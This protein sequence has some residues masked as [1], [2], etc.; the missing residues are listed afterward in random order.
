MPPIELDQAL[1]PGNVH[2][3]TSSFSSNDWTGYFYPIGMKPGDFL[4][5]YGNYFHT[6]EI[7]ATW[8]AMPSKRVVESWA[9]RTPENFI[10]SLKVPK[11]ITH[12]RYLE[13]CASEWGDFLE[14]L[15]PLGKKLGPLLLQ[16]PVVAGPSDGGRDFVRRLD[17][18]LEASPEDLRVVVE[19]RNEDWLAEPLLDLLRR[20]GASLALV[21][22]HSMPSGP[23]L[24]ERLDPLT[25][26]F[27]YVR[28]L[29]HHREMDLLV[30]RAREEGRRKRDW[31]TVL[32]D[33]EAETRAWMETIET[34][35][36]RQRDVFVYFN[37][38]YAGFAPGSVELFLRL[39]EQRSAARS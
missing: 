28:F 6:V 39:W 18:F 16:F 12:E 15:E 34:L 22:F 20:R 7:D 9:K 36:G 25:A 14:V 8:H 4:A 1:V 26:P 5:Y 30:A 35:S 10:F 27:S 24:F 3:G 31:E 32:V 13:G 37:N 2:L 21:E 17:R 33:R 11:T 29:G 23:A 19:V 38:H